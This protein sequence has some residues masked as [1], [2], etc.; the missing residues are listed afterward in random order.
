ML[1]TELQDRTFLAEI[2]LVLNGSTHRV[3]S[4]PSDAIALAVRVEASIFASED[5]LDE[6]ATAA[7]EEPEEQEDQIVDE[8]RA[9]I[10]QVRPEDFEK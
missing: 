10:E 1:V 5:V 4:R 8:F 2:E 6:A 3:S 9:F 7:A